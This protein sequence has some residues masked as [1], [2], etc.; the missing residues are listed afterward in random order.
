MGAMASTSKCLARSN[1]SAGRAET[2]KER[3]KERPMSNILK[4]VDLTDHA[5][6]RAVFAMLAAAHRANRKG[7]ERSSRMQE[8]D[9]HQVREL[10][11]G[12]HE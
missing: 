5:I 9:K 4:I 7:S 11:G 3:P 1:K 6:R 12:R 2:T 8:C 10:I